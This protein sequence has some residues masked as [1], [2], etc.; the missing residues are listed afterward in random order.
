[1]AIM[2]APHTA[3]A[4]RRHPADAEPE[5]RRA[6]RELRMLYETADFGKHHVDLLEGR[7]VVSPPADGPHELVVEWL[8]DE[9]REVSKAH[10]WA[11]L[12]GSG[13]AVPPQGEWIQPDFLIHRDRSTITGGW[14]YPAHQAL[15]VAEVASPSSVREDREVKPERC[16]LAGIPFYLLIDRLVTPMTLTLFSEPSDKGYAKT[17]VVQIGGKLYIPEPFDLTLDT[18]TLPR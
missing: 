16:A 8:M 17:D 14:L 12:A 9:F 6:R 2:H 13:V 15:L 7:L 1:M 10:G 3:P 5:L 11:R 4:K 18:T